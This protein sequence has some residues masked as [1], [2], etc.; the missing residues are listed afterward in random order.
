MKVLSA[1][2]DWD[3]VMFFLDIRFMWFGVQSFTLVRNLIDFSDSNIHVNGTFK[4][5][6]T[7]WRTKHGTKISSLTT[8]HVTWKSLL[9]KGNYCNKFDNSKLK[10]SESYWADSTWSTGRPPTN[11]QAQNYMTSLFRGGGGHRNKDLR[12]MDSLTRLENCQNYPSLVYFL[13]L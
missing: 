13:I 11:R 7:Y 8:E 12:K 4:G 1:G 3:Q 9:S 2:C 6:I 10:K 5:I